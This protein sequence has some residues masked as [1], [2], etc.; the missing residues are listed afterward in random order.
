MFLTTKEVAISQEEASKNKAFNSPSNTFILGVLGGIFISLGAFGSIIM[1]TFVADIGLGKF[2]AGTVFSVALM[3]VVLSG[4][5][6]FT[7]NNLITVG[8]LT[9]QFSW[10]RVGVNW[11]FVFIGNFAGAL[12]MVLIVYGT[13]LLGLNGDPTLS[14]E[15]SVALATEKM[16]LTFLEAITR[17]IL[18]N[19][20]VAG[21]VWMQTSAK[22][23]A[24]KVL[25]IFFP[26]VTFIIS[27]FEHVVANMFYIPMGMI[28]GANISIPS[29]L[30]D[31]IL[32]VAIGNAISGGLI[33][34][35]L[36]YLVYLKK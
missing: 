3:F 9:K 31:N 11:T 1:Y 14:G 29:L 35:G 13:G 15:T 36:Y 8:A 27:G 12:A 7:G 22:D 6:F 26:I 33:I 34:P 2:L 28:L 25:T 4:G 23:V 19:L 10:W 32:P 16:N 5:E 30:I 24:G 20:L 17:G 21:A 18:C